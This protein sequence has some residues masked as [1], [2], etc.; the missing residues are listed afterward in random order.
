MRRRRTTWVRSSLPVRVARPLHAPEVERVAHDQVPRIAPAAAEADAAD[1]QVA[2]IMRFALPR[3][4]LK[5][6]STP[7]EEVV[8]GSPRL[9]PH[10][11]RQHRTTSVTGLTG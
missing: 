7:H 8:G 5:S 11:R 3:G 1:E 10:D 4:P 2:A 6:G 9:P